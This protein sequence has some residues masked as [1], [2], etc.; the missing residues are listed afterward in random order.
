MNVS[1]RGGGTNEHVLIIFSNTIVKPDAF[2]HA[3]LPQINRQGSIENL[4]KPL[5][6]RPVDK[7]N[8]I[9]VKNRSTLSIETQLASETR[10][11]SFGSHCKEPGF[12]ASG[13]IEHHLVTGTNTFESDA[14]DGELESGKLLLE[15]FPGQSSIQRLS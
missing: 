3:K 1:R 15:G 7:L 13:D 4:G 6:R 2:L 10:D 5:E 8:K 9:F 11:V 12:L 14:P